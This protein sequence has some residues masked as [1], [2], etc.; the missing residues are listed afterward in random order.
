MMV[1]IITETPIPNNSNIVEYRSTNSFINKPAQNTLQPEGMFYYFNFS[2]IKM[3]VYNTPASP[4]K[5]P[6]PRGL[7]STEYHS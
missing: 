4:L 3:A 5:V 2:N 1:S 6:E 7:L